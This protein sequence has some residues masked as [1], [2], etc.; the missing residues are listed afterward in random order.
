MKSTMAKVLLTHAKRRRGKIIPVHFELVETE[1]ESE[2]I[3]TVIAEIF[4][5]K[6]K[7]DGFLGDLIETRS[8][9]KTG[10]T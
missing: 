5:D 7:R 9:A 3:N 8:D 6:M 10:A 2:D 1:K 4:F